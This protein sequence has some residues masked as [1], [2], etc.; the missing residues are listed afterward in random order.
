[1]EVLAGQ[2]AF[3]Q[4]ND[5]LPDNTIEMFDKYGIGIKGPLTTP[6]GG[7]IRSINVS[8][9]QKLDLYAC[10]RPLRWFRG[11]ETPTKR[12][13]DVDIAL[14]RENTEDVYSGKELEVNSDEVLALNQFLKS[15]FGKCAKLLGL[16]HVAKPKFTCTNRRRYSRKRTVDCLRSKTGRP[17]DERSSS[18]DE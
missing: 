18:G 14:F 2:K 10:V 11:V 8:I 15:E 16:K 13:G 17:G 7:G 4:Q 5:W 9:R 1:M 12:P 6:V 3:D